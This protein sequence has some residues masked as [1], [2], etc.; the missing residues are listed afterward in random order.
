MTQ[1]S[2]YKRPLG[3]LELAALLSSLRLQLNADTS[4]D[5]LALV[6]GFSVIH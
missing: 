6:S 1:A 4:G 5:V 3:L 2:W